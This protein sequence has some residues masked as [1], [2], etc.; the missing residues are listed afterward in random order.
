MG[1][2]RWFFP[3]KTSLAAEGIQSQAMTQEDTGKS[4]TNVHCIIIALDE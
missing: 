1:A 3:A 4:L 2:A